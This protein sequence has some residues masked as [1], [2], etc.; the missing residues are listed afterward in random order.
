LSI[1][2]PNC[3]PRYEP[4]AKVKV[5]HIRQAVKQAANSLFREQ[6]AEENARKERW[7]EEDRA[8]V[9]EEQKARADAAALTARIEHE[10]LAELEEEERRQRA[11]RLALRRQHKLDFVSVYGQPTPRPLGF[12]G[13][14][15]F[16]IHDLAAGMDPIELEGH[17]GATAIITARRQ[18]EQDRRDL[19]IQQ[20]EDRLSRARQL[21][22]DRLAPVKWAAEKEA[23]AAAHALAKA[24]VKRGK[25]VK[26]KR[27]PQ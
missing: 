2:Q 19:L 21:E 20:E 8:R 23:K 25:M 1:I 26:I 5:N 27:R 11:A 3:K 17:Y 22:A 12:G 10:R 6:L 16:R 24:N 15:Q 18:Q 4:K 9:V 13:F 7:A 14:G